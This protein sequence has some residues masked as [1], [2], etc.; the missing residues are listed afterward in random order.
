MPSLDMLIDDGLT[1]H[2]HLDVGMCHKNKICVDNH[3]K[4]NSNVDIIND[5]T[6]NCVDATLACIQT[7]S[8]K[9]I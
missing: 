4:K 2:G 3:K 7:T 8:D 6:D 1:E 9:G 5:T